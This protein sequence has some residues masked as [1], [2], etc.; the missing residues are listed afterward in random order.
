MSYIL[1]V[2]GS[3]RPNSVNQVITPLVVSELESR[4][5]DVKIANLKELNL[6]FYDAAAPSLSPDFVTTY[7]SVL[8]WTALVKEAAGVVLVTP[9][10]NHT[11]TPV[12][13]NAVDWI[14]KEWEDKPV[15]LVGYGWSG[16]SLAHA[17]AREVMAV[18]LKAKV[19]DDPTSLYFK[20]H[21]DVD[22]SLLEEVE[23]KEK[24]A[25]T[26]TE[27]LEAI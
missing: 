9:E 14:G 13:L 5:Q 6:P 21:L 8:A 3:I 11:M 15:A 12:Q 26:M 20:R 16:A 1:V 19:G 27:L 17:T 23:V 18:N 7:E 2:T 4:G 24:I 25:T 22:G 10:Y